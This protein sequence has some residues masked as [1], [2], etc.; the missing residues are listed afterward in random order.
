MRKT[1]AIFQLR[2]SL[3]DIEPAIWRSVQVPED[4]KLPR[5]HRILQFFPK[6]P[7]C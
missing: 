6:L 5:L 2:V 7:K 3:R 4:T 1:K